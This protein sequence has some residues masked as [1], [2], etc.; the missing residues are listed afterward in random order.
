MILVRHTGEV[1]CVER[2]NREGAA[3][4][5]VSRAAVEVW[6]L[7]R[8]WRRTPRVRLLSR[9]ISLAPTGAGASRPRAQTGLCGPQ[10]PEGLDLPHRADTGD[11]VFAGTP[12]C[13]NL[14]ACEPAL[15]AD[16]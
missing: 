5:G 2:A 12:I 13:L 16:A 6:R 4:C 11:P 1:R 8:A 14:D 7:L 9:L 10:S 3:T 15:P